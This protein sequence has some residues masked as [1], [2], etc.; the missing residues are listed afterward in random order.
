MDGPTFK[1]VT[2]HIAFSRTLIR[3]GFLSHIV[4]PLLFRY[5]THVVVY[6]AKDVL[7]FDCSLYQPYYCS[8]LW[9]MPSWSPTTL[10]RLLNTNSR[11]SGSTA[12]C[13]LRG[14]HF[15][16]LG[17]RR[18]LPGGRWWWHCDSLTKQLHQYVHGRIWCWQPRLGLCRGH[19]FGH[20]AEC[21]QC[22]LS[23]PRFTYWIVNWH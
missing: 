13:F 12:L 1:L 17:C 11:P 10:V 7:F 23:L 16:L 4:L 3:G 8:I 9:Q 19:Q 5:P 22:R 21:S 14:V 20:L 2:C 15:D 18:P 6:A